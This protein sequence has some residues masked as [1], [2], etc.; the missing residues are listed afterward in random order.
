V[1]CT[2]TAGSNKALR[3]LSNWTQTLKVRFMQ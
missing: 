2:L 1:H 3:R